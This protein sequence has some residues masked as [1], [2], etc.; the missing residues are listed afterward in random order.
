MVDELCRRLDGLPLAL[1]LAAARTTS[2]TVAEILENLEPGLDLLTRPRRR[3]PDR[4]RSLSAAIAW[5]HRQLDDEEQRL[6]AALSI[7]VASFTAG[8]AASA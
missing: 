7:P 6:F 3:G 1:E 4:H 2:L 5:S 8:M